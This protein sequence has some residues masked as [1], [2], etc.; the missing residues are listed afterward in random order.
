[1]ALQR[2]GTTIDVTEYNSR[3]PVRLG[4]YR[5]NGNDPMV[6][7]TEE[8]DGM[9]LVVVATGRAPLRND[10]S[11]EA[12][13]Q[14]DLFDLLQWLQEERPELLPV[15][16]GHASRLE[17]QVRDLESKL[18]AARAEAS[19]LKGEMARI[20]EA[21]AKRL[22]ERPNLTE[23]VEA[24]GR[25]LF[26]H[27]LAHLAL[28]L[29][30]GGFVIAEALGGDIGDLRAL[31]PDRARDMIE[32]TFAAIGSTHNKRLANA[33]AEEC[34]ELADVATMSVTG[35]ATARAAALLPELN[36]LVEERSRA[37]ANS[38]GHPAP[39]TTRRLSQS[40]TVVRVRDLLREIVGDASIPRP[41]SDLKGLKER[42]G[43][44]ASQMRAPRPGDP[45]GTET[46]RMAVETRFVGA[47]H[48][49]QVAG[50]TWIDGSGEGPVRHDVGLANGVAVLA[51]GPGSVAACS[52]QHVVTKNGAAV[53]VGA[54]FQKGDRISVQPIVD[55]VDTEAAE[56]TGAVPGSI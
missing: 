41:V 29:G 32:R 2:P 33:I 38:L 9:R 56:L 20:T 49:T 42:F 10:E 21:R 4:V 23:A 36:R 22:R 24:F 52:P 18:N 27:H 48:A 46:E 43:I 16:A 19:T 34:C 8:A 25:E 17:A 13:V 39:Q 55:T 28:S 6:S 53:P 54:S 30:N 7:V 26:A 37:V 47:T 14:I 5:P 15:D 11:D 51:G 1:M 50:V 3:E 12:E 35:S 45:A 44:H 40:D 31:D